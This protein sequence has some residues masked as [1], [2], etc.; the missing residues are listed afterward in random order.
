M[1]TQSLRGMANHGPM[2]WRGDRTGGDDRRPSARR[3]RHLRRGAAFKKFNVAFA[4]LLG[5][6]APLTDAEMQAFTDFIL[7]VTYPPNPIRELDNSLTADQAGGPRLLLRHAR[8]RQPRSRDTFH[9]C[10]GCHVARSHGQRPVRRGQAGLLRQRRTYSFENETQNFKVPHLRN[11][12]QKV[13]MFGMAATFDPTLNARSRSAARQRRIVPGRSGARLRLPAR[14]Q[15]RHAC[16]ASTPAPSSPS[17]TRP[18]RSRTR[19]A[20]PWR[21][22]N[23][24]PATAQQKVLANIQLRRQLEAFMLAFDSNLAPIVG[25]QATLTRGPDPRCRRASS[26]SKRGRRR[27]SATWSVHGGGREAAAATSIIRRREP[28]DPNR[29]A[30]RALGDHGTLRAGRKYGRADLHRRPPGQRPPDSVSIAT[31]TASST[32]RRGS[33][34]ARRAVSPAPTPARWYTRAGAR[35]R[36]R[37]ARPTRRWWRPCAPRGSSSRPPA[38]PGPVVAEA[39]AT[40]SRAGAP[41]APDGGPRLWLTA[42]ACG[43]RRRPGGG[44]GRCLRRH[45]RHHRRG[46]GHAGRAAARAGDV[47]AGD[48]GHRALRRRERGGAGACCAR[49]PT[50]RARRCRCC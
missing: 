11:L 3:T 45:R 31:W 25:Q 19:A 50:R 48:P 2:H 20:F 6:S 49:L 5:R 43:R 13:G 29:A 27:A 10:N 30:R 16:S 23:D 21:W 35:V 17:A 15:H 36:G 47:R 32:G 8:R 37:G 34:P 18:A 38:S 41:R 44:R 28:L 46:P 12:Y 39:I 14:R 1:T 24:D 9:N 7:Q 33:P 26:C 42:G 22:P 40:A 4:G